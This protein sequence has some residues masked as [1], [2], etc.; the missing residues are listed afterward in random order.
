[1]VSIAPAISIRILYYGI[2]YFLDYYEFNTGIEVVI[3][4]VFLWC[5]YIAHV[6]VHNRKKFNYGIITTLLLT[7]F[8]TSIVAVSSLIHYA[9]VYLDKSVIEILKEGGIVLWL[10]LYVFFGPFF[11][12]VLLSGK[13]HSLMLMIKSFIPYV[14]FLHMLIAWFGSYSYSRIWD[15]TWGNRPANELTDL[16]QEQRDFMTT[17]FKEIS[18]KVIIVL[19]ILNIGVFFIP[20]SG[21]IYMMMVF[22]CVAAFQMVFS[23]IYCIRRLAYKIG[24]GFKKCRMKCNRKNVIDELEDPEEF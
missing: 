4:S 11:L 17:K 9:F 21:H 1:M 13:G 19:V 15:L 23:T 18:I 8:L 24:F 10:G 14:L 6:S 22:F 20:L 16:T 2:N 3:L 12:S 7:S 5:M